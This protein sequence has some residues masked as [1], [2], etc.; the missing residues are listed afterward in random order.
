[1]TNIFISQLNKKQSATQSNRNSKNS[2]RG[3]RRNYGMESE[4]P[5]VSVPGENDQPEELLQAESAISEIDSSLQTNTDAEIE[6]AA[7]EVA[8]EAIRHAIA[9][10]IRTAFSL[11]SLAEQLQETVEGDGEGIEPATA[12]LITTAIEPTAGSDTLP[13]LES[14]SYN[15]RYATE[16]MIDTV[17]EKAKGYME[18]VVT[19]V[20]SVTATTSQWLRTV[21]DNLRK[22]KKVLDE[23]RTKL[24][25]LEGHSGKP[26]E[27]EH[28]LKH[29]NKFIGL[30]VSGKSGDGAAVINQ[31]LTKS[32]PTLVN[33]ANSMYEALGNLVSSMENPDE[34]TLS[35]EAKRFYDIARKFVN[36]MADSD[37]SIT[38]PETYDLATLASPETAKASINLEDK[39]DSGQN[40]LTFKII[41]SAT[42]EKLEAA[43]GSCGEAMQGL[44][45][46]T[47]KKAQLGENLIKAGKAKAGKDEEE[48]SVQMRKAIANVIVGANMLC[49]DAARICGSTAHGA[50]KCVLLLV[51]A[52]LRAAGIAAKA[53]PETSDDSAG[54]TA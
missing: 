18:K 23:L 50:E 31:V 27:D 25:A 26:I 30:H 39:S 35:R 40:N 52:S 14:F 42:F 22:T 41:D 3:Y 20:R 49:R 10:S 38:A 51:R 33:I 17:K 11:E 15:R 21:T 46:S 47:S 45:A 36:N 1:M 19:T 53:Q 43:I 54:A 7:N 28:I 5:G 29:L 4:E 37:Y 9:G 24:G 32:V 16:S 48:N 6:G 2:T 12:E 34:K 13:A 44:T 8:V